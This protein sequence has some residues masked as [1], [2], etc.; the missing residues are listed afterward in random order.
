MTWSKKSN[1]C[2]QRLYSNSTI[3]SLFSDDADH[4]DISR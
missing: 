3:L 1:V 2:Y 4:A